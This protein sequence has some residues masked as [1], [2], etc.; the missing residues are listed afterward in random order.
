MSPNAY[1]LLVA[2]GASLLLTA[3]QAVVTSPGDQGPGSPIGSTSAEFT[4]DEDAAPPDVAMNRLTRDQF[5]NTLHDLLSRYL[6]EARTNEV[7]DAHGAQHTLLPYD[8]APPRANNRYKRDYRRWDQT[9]SELHV[10]G[11]YDTAL[12]IGTEVATNDRAALLGDCG[13]TVECAETFLRE[14]AS[15][16]FRHP[17]PDDTWER[18]R[19]AL[20]D[21]VTPTALGETIAYVL[22]APDFLYHVEEGADSVGG[23]TYRLS[24][25]ELAARMSYALWDS[26]PD[27]ELWAA[28]ESG[29]LTGN[30]DVFAAQVDR[31]LVDP[32]SAPALGRFFEDWLQFQ[33]AENPADLSANPAFQS[34][35]GEDMPTANLREAGLQEMRDLVAQVLSSGGSARDLV[36]TDLAPVRDAELAALYGMDGPWDGTSEPPRFAEGER[37]G[38]LSRFTFLATATVATRPIHRGVIIRENIL[39][40][41]LPAPPDGASSTTLDLDGVYST[42]EYVE[43]LTEQ[44][45]TACIGCHQRW[46]NPLGFVSEHYDALSRLRTEETVF[47]LET[48]AIRGTTPIDTTVQASIFQGDQA[49][50]SSMQELGDVIADSGKLEACISRNLFRFVFA[51]VE[52][53][54]EDGCALESSRV[55]GQ[56][57]SLRDLI[58]AMVLSRAFRL[59]TIEE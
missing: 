19:M 22:L 7:L 25:Y 17:V 1:R 6:G 56:D 39:C 36:T 41:T 34:F 40:D 10:E 16:A 46:I 49:E 26:L 48:G 30:D 27:D 13:D 4:C 29:D 12:A 37:P 28:A 2:L 50:I 15:R 35:A 38:M 55:A 11:W 31:M 21:A 44:P 3:C 58:A 33:L 14:F 54:D 43:E 45:G 9:V 51:R 52:D 42:R 32:R 5:D 59:R 8:E 23:A 47:D 57:G 24:D 20:G 18:I 53:V